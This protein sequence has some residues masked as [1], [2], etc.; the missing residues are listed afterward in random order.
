MQPGKLLVLWVWINGIIRRW[1][2]G[3]GGNRCEI[4][5]DHGKSPPPWTE[6]ENSILIT[7][8]F[9]KYL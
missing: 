8:E 9:R 5:L 4:K 1:G 7:K 2:G 3:G 6:L